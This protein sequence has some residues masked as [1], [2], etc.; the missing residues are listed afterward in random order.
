MFPFEDL[1]KFILQVLVHRA[2]ILKEGDGLSV[3]Q[4]KETESVTGASAPI[5]GFMADRHISNMT[6]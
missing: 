1:G 2:S 5:T 3:P 6:A 4:T